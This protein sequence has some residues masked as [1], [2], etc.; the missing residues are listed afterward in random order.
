[1]TD[2]VLDVI[3]HGGTAGPATTPVPTPHP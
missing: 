2:M 1:L 3:E